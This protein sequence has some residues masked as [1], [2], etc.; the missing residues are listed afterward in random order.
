MRRQIEFVNKGQRDL[1]YPALSERNH[2]SGTR[3]GAFPWFTGTRW[4]SHRLFVK[5]AEYLALLR[6][7]ASASIS[8]VP[9]TVRSNFEDMSRIRE[10]SD[11]LVAV[12]VLAQPGIGQTRIR[13]SASSL[14]ERWPPVPQGAIL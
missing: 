12:D 3:C 1:W 5:M 8:T 9:E 11:A 6:D 14:G 4:E 13:S 7:W 10:I 2:C